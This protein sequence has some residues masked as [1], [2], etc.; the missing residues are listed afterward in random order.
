MERRNGEEEEERREI[1]IFLGYQK[2][3]V[4]HRFRSLNYSLHIAKIGTSSRCVCEYKDYDSGDSF[5]YFEM[6]P[7]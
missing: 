5:M 7:G 1:E 3:S 6:K 4:T 2:S